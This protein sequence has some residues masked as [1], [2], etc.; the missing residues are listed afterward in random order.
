MVNDL[1]VVNIAGLTGQ[2]HRVTASGAHRMVLKPPVP[3]MCS[4]GQFAMCSQSS[5]ELEFRLN[6]VKLIEVEGM[7]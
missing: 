2:P 3:T 1:A 4:C 5:P 7:A 6:A